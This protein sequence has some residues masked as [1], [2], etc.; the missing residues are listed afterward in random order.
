MSVTSLI[1]CALPL[2]VRLSKIPWT[3]RSFYAAL[4]TYAGL[5]QP[6]TLVLQQ[7]PPLVVMQRATALEVPVLPP[8][9]LRAPLLPSGTA[10]LTARGPSK[11]AYSTKNATRSTSTLIT[12]AKLMW[13]PTPPRPSLPPVTHLLFR[14]PNRATTQQRSLLT[15]RSLPTISPIAP[16]GAEVLVPRVTPTLLPVP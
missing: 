10:S 14:R 15:L 5:P 2:A 6:G 1:G 3:F 11:D 8:R 9:L 12:G 16:Q 7:T 13:I 4:P